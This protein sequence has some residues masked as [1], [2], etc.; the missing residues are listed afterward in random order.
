[1]VRLCREHGLETTLPNALNSVCEIGLILGRP[2]EVVAWS[3]EG[4]R[5]ST[6]SMDMYVWHLMQHG[7]AL[8]EVGDADGA[9]A[10]LLTA[11]DLYLREGLGVEGMEVV[12]RL[13]AVA[14]RT[15]EPELAATL[16][17]AFEAVT[18]GTAVAAFPG[19]LR[20]QRVHLADL[21][22]RLG[23][24]FA[25]NR[26]RGRDLVRDK[27]LRG[28]FT[29]VLALLTTPGSASGSQRVGSRAG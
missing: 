15:G 21:P 13:A 18:A 11:L 27:D 29:A 19:V 8:L 2:D 26:T 1:M 24:T 9:Q 23:P 17:A 25:V 7:L 16:G 22:D 28:A 5:L 12:L 4:M 20:V 3:E 10:E 14:A 6:E